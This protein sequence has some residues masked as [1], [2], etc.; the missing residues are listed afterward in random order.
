MFRVVALCLALGVVLLLV[1]AVVPLWSSARSLAEL[2]CSTHAAQLGSVLAGGSAFMIG[3]GAWLR[4]RR[5]PVGHKRAQ[6]STQDAHPNVR[7]PDG[8]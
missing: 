2:L 4:R 7:T 1:A 6:R 8:A 5:Q 3:L